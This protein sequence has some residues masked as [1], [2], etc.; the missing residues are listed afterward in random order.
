MG[1]TTEANSGCVSLLREGETVKIII[2]L[3][4]IAGML[5]L[6]GCKPKQTTLAGQVFIVTQGADNVKLGDADILLI[7]K[8][9]VTDFLHKKQSAIEA[10]KESRLLE[11]H[12]RAQR[13]HTCQARPHYR[14]NF[15]TEAWS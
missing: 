12:A 2:A 5:G 13:K 4:A 8:S 11:L 6:A 15:R 1:W 10:E 9:N 7:E 14:T 3:I